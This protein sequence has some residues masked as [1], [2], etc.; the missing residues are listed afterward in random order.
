MD[1]AVVKAQRKVIS[2][3]DD[4]A[5]M[6]VVDSLNENLRDVRVL[7]AGLADDQRLDKQLKTLLVRVERAERDAKKVWGTAKEQQFLS[8]F[9]SYAPS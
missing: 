7:I 3:L 5:Y 1:A 9:P 2:E 8:P 4:T 6:F